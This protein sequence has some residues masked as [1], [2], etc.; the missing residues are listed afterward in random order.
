LSADVPSATQDARY[1]EFEQGAS[2]KFWEIAVDG[3]DVKVRFG[4]I[5]SQGQTQVKSFDDDATARAHAASMIEK[6][7]SAGYREPG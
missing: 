3:P 1:F 6:K 5:G 7:T 2:R 4:R